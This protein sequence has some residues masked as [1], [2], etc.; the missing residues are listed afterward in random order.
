M[1]NIGI[2]KYTLDKYAEIIFT[3]LDDIISGTNNAAL[4]INS[5]PES[6]NDVAE[7]LKYLNEIISETRSFARE[8]STGNLNCKLPSPENEIAAPLKS[9]YASLMHLTW[10]AKRVA[11]GDYFQR[12]SFMGDFSVA[13]NN[14]VEQLDQRQ[15]NNIRE[16]ERLE[17][18]QRELE[19]ANRGKSVFFAKMSHE[20]RTPMNA[21]IGMTELAL[22][23]DIP[24]AAQEYINTIKHAG[25]NL[26]AIINDILDFSKIET[27]KL[28]IV[29]EKYVLSF[30][31][32]DVI[33]I[34][35][36][37]VLESHLNFL[38]NIDNNIPNNLYGDAV[39]IRQIF[40]NL[41]SNAVKYTQKGCISLSVTGKM[42]DN[43]NI[44]LNIEVADTGK[45]IKEEDIKKLFSEFTRV[46]IASNANVEGT[47]LGLAI[48]KNLIV[49][50]GGEINV[51]S[52]YG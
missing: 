14:M 31:V 36:T 1:S 11:D 29:P 37:K 23:E 6:F 49:A 7:G 47:G 46:D 51:Q 32:S 9:L 44:I 16:K 35:K 27:G 22:R 43:D 26:L 5:L 24:L 28:E 48:T 40:M 34:I 3:Y 4:S 18:M 15:Q 30:L 21:I 12:V 20:M 42:I 8:L 45:G 13:F 50:M 2:D 52:E 19:S 25:T 17:N 41:L 38:V 10:Q 39:R 33:S